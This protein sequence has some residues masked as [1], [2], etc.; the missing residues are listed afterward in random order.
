[1]DLTTNIREAPQKPWKEWGCT[2][3]KKEH[4]KK[5]GIKTNVF[6]LMP[7]NQVR[8]RVVMMGW[9]MCIVS[10]ASHDTTIYQFR[11]IQSIANNNK[12]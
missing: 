1:L 3:K 4:Q 11:A 6:S 2:R 12:L 7:P 5:E 10:T 8:S 9:E